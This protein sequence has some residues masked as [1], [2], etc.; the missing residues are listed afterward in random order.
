MSFRIGGLN[1]SLD[2]HVTSAPIFDTMQ[3]TTAYYT[4]QRLAELA[5][6]SV[7]TLHHYDHLGLLKPSHRS[8]AGYRRYSDADLLRLQQILFY[9]E[10]DVPLRKIATILDD[11]DF[12]LVS[13]LKG[14]RHELTLRVERLRRLLQTIG[15]TITTLEDKTMPVSREDLYEGFAPDT[16][17]RYEREAKERY[18][19]DAVEDTTKRL[20]ALSKGEWD[21]VKKEGEAI[22]QELVPYLG[23]D[24]AGTEVQRLVVRHHRWIENFYPCNAERYRGLA[25]LYVSDPEFRRYYDDRHPGLADF[26]GTAM[27]EFAK[28]LE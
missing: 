14:H 17:E 8:E 1:V 23:T 6:V 3:Q 27:K 5:G 4:V 7:R 25:E 12:D 20:S 24:P 10:L 21:A 19:E 26:L 18:G 15:R 13:A 9:R 22:A 16:I 2:S 28:A 11:P